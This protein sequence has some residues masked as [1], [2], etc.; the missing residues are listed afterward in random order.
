MED[1]PLKPTDA[2]LEQESLDKAEVFAWQSNEP[3]AVIESEPKA[4]TVETHEMIVEALE[5]EIERLRAALA[6][7]AKI[8]PMFEA[9]LPFINPPRE[10][11]AR[12][13]FA[14]AALKVSR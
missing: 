14:E 11:E 4:M 1:Y 8:D 9:N 3:V 6:R 13:R 12:I 7:L 10:L 5:G 2:D